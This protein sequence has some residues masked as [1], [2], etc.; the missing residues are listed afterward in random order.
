MPASN[1]FQHRTRA[2]VESVG[3]NALNFVLQPL[4][5]LRSIRRE[6][7]PADLVAGLTVAAVAIPQA[8]AYASIVELP[9]QT[10]LYA[11]A[12]AA[13]VGS[14][15]GCSRHLATG[16][17]NA[18]SLLVL[19][20]LLT[21]ATPGTSAFLL[22]AG[23]VAVTVGLLNVLLAVL[24]FG[25]LVTLASRS[26]LVGFS[27]GAAVHIAFGQLRH[28]LGL[29]IPA[30][31][32]LYR[33]VGAVAGDLGNAHTISLFLGLGAMVLVVVLKHRS[34]RMPA[35]LIAVV[36][37]AIA[38]AVFGLEQRGVQVVGAIP[39]S[40]PPT[41]WSTTGLLPDLNMIRA[42]VV[43]SMAVA[44][45]GLI[46]AVAASQTLA[47]R[48][49]DRLD[50]N[51]EFFGQGLANIAAGLLSG[52]PVS[53]SFT[54]SALAQQS[55]GRTH[56]TG[57][58]TGLAIMAS[59]L[60]FAPYARLVPRPA[61]AAVLLFVAWGMID[62]SSI[63]R[64][65][66]TSRSETAI[67]GVTFLATL[68][69]PL[70]F[71]VLSGVVFSLAFFVIRS[72]LPRVVPVVPNPTYQH[73]VHNPGAPVCPQLAVMNI[74]G[75]LFFGAVYH[76]E[77]ELRHN[78]ENHPGQNFLV[79]RM[80]GVDI[81]D[82]SGIEMLEST[83]ATYRDFGGDV[84]LVRP[85]APVLAKLEQSGFLDDTLGRDH[86]LPPEGAIEYLFEKVLDPAVC[87]YECHERIFAECMA[88]E[89]HAYDI[90]MPPVV[91]S[92]HDHELNLTTE[93]FHKLAGDPDTMLLDVRE[94][95]EYSRGHLPGAGLL[96][97]RMLPIKAEDLP[98]DRSLLLYC[99]SGR[100][101]ALALHILEDMGVSKLHGLKGGLLAWRAAGLP[102]TGPADE[103]LDDS[104]PWQFP[105]MPV[106][107]IRQK[108]VFTRQRVERR[109]AKLTRKLDRLS[110]T[111]D[112]TLLQETV[113]KLLDQRVDSPA[114]TGGY[115]TLD[116]QRPVLIISDS[117]TL[118]D[119]F[120]KLLHDRYIGATNLESLARGNLQ[121]LLL[122]DLLHS[123]SKGNWQAAEDEYVSEFTAAAEATGAS[124]CLD[125]EMANGFGLA[126]MI[127]TLQQEIPGVLYLK[128]NHDNILNSDEF[129]NGPLS[130][131][132]S[133]PGEGEIARAWTLEKFGSSFAGKYAAWENQLPIFAVY[134]NTAGGL[135]FVAS[136]SE[137]D[138]PYTLDEIEKRADKTV[139]GLTWTRNRGV[140]APEVLRN[141]FGEAWPESCYFVSHTGS[142]EGIVRIPRKKLVIVNKPRHLVTVLVL[143]EATDFEVHMIASR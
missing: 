75:P 12:V 39:R 127:L 14:L 51:Q 27:T 92:H 128:G 36:V 134:D 90:E 88:V 29:D 113:E 53:G 84:F 138:R 119:A 71:A 111:D 115:C 101:T 60:L 1:D 136:H 74:R 82:L 72:S 3:P 50:S 41:T 69:L 66:K 99:R 87:T 125:G 130:K 70:D 83:V 23:V 8:I 26:V 49:G 103:E 33:T 112:L 6:D 73:L 21:V 37:S 56:L 16:P 123:E 139:F 45:L 80:H 85:R 104:R 4:T 40:L 31:P 86:I 15:W 107:A 34:Q 67:M 35:A 63:R 141:V 64:V 102:F 61:I 98:R 38:V 91:R 108:Q 17:V 18:T 28:L 19:P 95:E 81:C 25:A 97:L 137:P 133:W 76:L 121:L 48:S 46:E 62:R 96:P 55:G 124:P 10:G 120:N 68:L 110:T 11:A 77:E 140:Y 118:R 122:G 20:V 135:K 94:P 78:H 132:V 117:H 22:A 106:E 47:R 43:G 116:P 93:A 30:M 114:R 9:A 105:A 131:Y 65:L 100:R 109:L 24:R 32:E 5:I 54:R 57:V 58:F 52:Y 129:G 142:E 143:P 13:V 89:K 42:L 2:A 126:A 59:M 79:L 44:A 7:V